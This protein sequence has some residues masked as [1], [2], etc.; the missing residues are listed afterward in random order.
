MY[1]YT[2]AL[3]RADQL[4]AALDSRGVIDQAKGILM[5]RFKLDAD[6]AFQALAR[7]SME[8]N[9]KVREIAERFVRTR[10]LR[11]R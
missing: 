4:A 11:P 9:L 5:E 2:S 1:L 10:D 6:Q 3:E 7:V 8:S